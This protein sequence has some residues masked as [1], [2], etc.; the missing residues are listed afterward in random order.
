[1]LF[2]FFTSEREPRDHRSKR[3]TAAKC[4]QPA[5]APHTTGTRALRPNQAWGAP[6]VQ[7]GMH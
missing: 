1:M 6:Q 7:D 5:F 2:F 4:A 3:P